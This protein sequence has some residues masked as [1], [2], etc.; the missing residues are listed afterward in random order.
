MENE[1]E[2]VVPY[3]TIGSL[4]VRMP[5]VSLK[6]M[7]KSTATII[8]SFQ[9]TLKGGCDEECVFENS[10]SNDK[11]SYWKISPMNY[12]AGR[13]CYDIIWG[14]KLDL[15]ETIQL[16][17]LYSGVDNDA[18]GSKLVS[19]TWSL[20]FRPCRWLRLPKTRRAVRG[21]KFSWSNTWNCPEFRLAV[22]V[23]PIVIL[24][25]KSKDGMLKVTHLPWESEPINF[26]QLF[27]S[28]LV[29]DEDIDWSTKPPPRVTY[30]FTE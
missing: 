29:F 3:S 5:G 8:P 10:T 17:V 6:I 15:H 14:E 24:P 27:N 28:W 19:T 11:V 22:A 12:A 13:M 2:N 20:D 23:I 26:S 16:N 18:Q 21:I 9:V 1:I 4:P 25:D 30:F 7:C